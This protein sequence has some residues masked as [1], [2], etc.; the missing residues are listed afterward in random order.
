[1]PYRNEKFWPECEGQLEFVCGSCEGQRVIRSDDT[2]AE[3]CTD[4]DATG[5]DPA[6]FL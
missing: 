2:P 5:I 4:C 1:M 6:S 3:A